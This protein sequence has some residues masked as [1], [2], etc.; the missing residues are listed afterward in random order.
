VAEDAG[1]FVALN[2][3]VNNQ[4]CKRVMLLLPDK[5]PVMELPADLASLRLILRG[6][7]A[8]ARRR[9]LKRGS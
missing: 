4:L 7:G 1:Y 9:A 6:A 2:Q 5:Y 3:L 8:G